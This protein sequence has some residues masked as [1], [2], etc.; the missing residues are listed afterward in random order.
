MRIPG[1]PRIEFGDFLSAGRA[2]RH[3]CDLP[4]SRLNL[5]AGNIHA[6][7]KYSL[8]G[9]RNVSFLEF[10]AGFGWVE[11]VFPGMFG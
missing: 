7:G 10:R 5:Y 4:R 9:A 8:R 2:A 3:N 1:H 6:S 11:S